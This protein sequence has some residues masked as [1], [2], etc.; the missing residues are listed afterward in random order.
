MSAGAYTAAMANR[1]WLALGS[2]LLFF[3]CSSGEGS[4][5]AGGGSGGAAGSGATAGSGGSGAKDGGSGGSAG[6]AGDGGAAGSGGGTPC[7]ANLNCQSS[8][9]CV[10]EVYEPTNC[11]MLSDP[12]GTCPTE[13]IQTFCG[14]AGGICCCDPAPPATHGC[15]DTAG[16]ATPPTCACI[17]CPNSKMCTAVGSPS[18]GVFRCEEPPKP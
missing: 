8:E 16:C 11:N 14:G 1:G 10:E 18:S 15:V 13:K 7:G 5:P 9:A 6:A 17:Q 12:N 2:S 4:A 3:A